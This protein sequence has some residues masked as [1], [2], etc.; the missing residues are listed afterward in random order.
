MRDNHNTSNKCNRNE[1]AVDIY[2]T[3]FTQTSIG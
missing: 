3:F 2:E 1:F